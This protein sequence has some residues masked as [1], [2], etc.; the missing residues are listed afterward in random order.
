LCGLTF[1]IAGISSISNEGA[2]HGSRW[3][4]AEP[5]LYGGGHQRTN[6]GVLCRRT[7]PELSMKI[8][9]NIDGG[10]DAHDIIMSLLVRM[11]RMAALHG[12]DRLSA[13]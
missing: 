8:V 4:G 3:L 1:L 11:R 2:C 7:P 13:C 9:W 6:G 10:S 5:G 12:I